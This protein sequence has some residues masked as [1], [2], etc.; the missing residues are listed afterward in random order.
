MT[1]RKD[2]ATIAVIASALVFMAAVTVPLTNA[3][4][5]PQ[6]SSQEISS[7]QTVAAEITLTS[8]GVIPGSVSVPSG[9]MMQW[10]N[11]DTSAHTLTFDAASGVTTAP[12]LEPGQSF[13][14][15]F[16]QPGEFAYKLDT[17]EAAYTVTVR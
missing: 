2:F 16:S 9:G 3:S 8:E 5:P 12:S 14:V 1:I 11:Q 17:N 7:E 13:T 10:V 4:A 15:T 6:S